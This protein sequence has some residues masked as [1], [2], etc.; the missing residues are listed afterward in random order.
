[1]S[2]RQWCFLSSPRPVDGADQ[3][4][5][6]H[7]GGSVQLSIPRRAPSSWAAQQCGLTQRRRRLGPRCVPRHGCEGRPT[8]PS[9]RRTKRGPPAS[10]SGEHSAAPATCAPIDECPVRA[11]PPGARLI[12]CSHGHTRGRSRDAVQ[13]ARS[14]NA[15]PMRAFHANR[16]T[17]LET[18]IFGLR[19]RSGLASGVRISARPSCLVP[20]PPHRAAKD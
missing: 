17:G 3:R 2:G 15:R 5:R 16:T 8:R 9:H 6:G 19:S 10:P 13:A 12:R 4:T 18:A 11:S 1:M 14:P 20:S 7:L